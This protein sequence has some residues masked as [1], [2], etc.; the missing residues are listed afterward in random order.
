LFKLPL[1]S[2]LLESEIAGV[3]LIS[4]NI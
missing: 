2:M 1:L 3:P 4:T